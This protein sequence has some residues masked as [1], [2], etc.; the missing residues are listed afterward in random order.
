LT[1][2]LAA[3]YLRLKQLLGQY[4]AVAV[5]FSGGV[6]STL[7]LKAAAEVLGADKVLALTAKSPLYPEYEAAESVQL[8]REFGIRQLLIDNDELSSAAFVANDPQRCYHCKLALYRHFL[9]LAR[10]NGC[11][12]VLDGSNLDDLDDYR[13]GQQALQELQ[14]ASPLLEAGL[15]KAEIRQL[16]KQL[17]LPTW[18]KQAFACLA[19]R[20]PYGTEI[21]NERLRQVEQCEDWLRR[22]NFTNYRVRYHQQ[23]ARIE[24][25]PADIERLL[26]TKL[27]QKLVAAFKAAGFTYIT[28]DLEGYRTGSMNETLPEHET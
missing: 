15:K 23:L 14:I 16:S 1:A 11:Q 7:L 4:S 24:V 28:L 12:T 19:S 9:Q 27:R 13:P 3:K 17:G 25:P 21:T 6:D 18:A 5:A 10:E 22:H 8:S 20:I 26:D 2:E